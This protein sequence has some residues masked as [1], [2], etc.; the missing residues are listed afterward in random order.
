MNVTRLQEKLI[1]AARKNPPSDR[2]PYA[3]EQ[4]IMAR[5]RLKRPAMDLGAFWAHALWRA[6]APSLALML[7]LSAWA[8]YAPKPSPSAGDFSQDL[9]NTLLAAVDQ[10]QPSEHSW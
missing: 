8:I 6:V 9:E 7:L 1:A 2:V 5:L 10:D 4:R 3:F